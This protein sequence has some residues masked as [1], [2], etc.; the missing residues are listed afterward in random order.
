MLGLTSE[1]SLISS[2]SFLKNTGFS[3]PQTKTRIRN[4]S[5]GFCMS[6]PSSYLFLQPC[7]QYEDNVHFII[8]PDGNGKYNIYHQKT[9]TYLNF[10]WKESKRIMSFSKQKLALNIEKHEDQ[11]TFK[12]SLDVGQQKYCY[13]FTSSYLNL[14][15]C[16]QGKPDLL[17]FYNTFDQE[18]YRVLLES[19]VL[20][21]FG[22]ID[23]RTGV[24]YIPNYFP[25]N[26]FTYLEMV[27]YFEGYSSNLHRFK[28]HPKDIGVYQIINKDG[29]GIRYFAEYTIASYTKEDDQK[30]PPEWFRIIPVPYNPDKF[31]IKLHLKPDRM[32]H[33]NK[34]I[35]QNR[36]I[37]ENDY[38]Y[39]FTV[40]K[41]C[42]NLP[43]VRENVWY[44]LRDDQNKCITSKPF[45]D[46]IQLLP[47]TFKPEFFWKFNFDDKYKGYI[48]TQKSSGKV[49]QDFLNRQDTFLTDLKD[50]KAQRWD[51][52]NVEYRYLTHLHIVNLSTNK[53]IDGRYSG[54][55]RGKDYIRPTQPL[56]KLPREEQLIEGYTGT[57]GIYKP[58]QPP[59]NPPQPPVNPTQPPVNPPQPPV[60]PPQ[61][62]VNPTQPPVDPPKPPVNPP[63]PP[64]NPP[65]PP[66]DQSNRHI[67][68]YGPRCRRRSII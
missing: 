41:P 15:E 32:V 17:N 5:G 64:V 62:P 67:N 37:K 4:V 19:N 13:D 16:N 8:Q 27:D 23:I 34:L 61:P 10:E 52:L 60:N 45:S 47:C 12:V 24:S 58:P 26:P 44:H 48:I 14:V 46:G 53:C 3:V 59:V 38:E 21:S 31:M 6:Y 36:I 55:C 25:D 7:D 51:I 22:H 57:C 28:P 1:K 9:Q 20:Y 35:P 33:Y 30:N 66:V 43:P 68:H 54:I 42:N 65:Q 56:V 29:L 40:R 63:L 39:Q 18:P 49:L 50:E 2:L 11:N